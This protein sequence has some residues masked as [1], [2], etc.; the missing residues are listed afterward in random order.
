VEQP[1]GDVLGSAYS[2]LSGFL[3]RYIKS[4]ALS[5]LLSSTAFAR[6]LP[7]EPDTYGGGAGSFW[8]AVITLVI[9][10]YLAFKASSKA[11]KAAEFEFLKV[12]FGVQIVSLILF[13]N[14]GK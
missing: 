6:Y 8:W 2:H 13:I 1:C 7:N 4:L 3:A 9:A 10:F 5:F 11:Q 14:F 12:F